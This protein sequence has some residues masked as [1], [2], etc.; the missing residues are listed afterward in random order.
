M[1]YRPICSFRAEMEDLGWV[2]GVALSEIKMGK[3]KALKISPLQQ[4]PQ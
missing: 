2:E 3:V 4:P 1:S